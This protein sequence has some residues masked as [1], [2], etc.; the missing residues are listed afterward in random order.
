MAE[1][2]GF[3]HRQTFFV[4]KKT[5]MQMSV[6]ELLGVR[7]EWADV[8]ELMNA[9]SMLGQAVYRIFKNFMSQGNALSISFF[10]I[11]IISGFVFKEI[12]SRRRGE[13]NA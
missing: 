12:R 13:G 4:Y 8:K 5:G 7:T 10:M 6:L 1:I 11:G 9:V 2:S 3:C